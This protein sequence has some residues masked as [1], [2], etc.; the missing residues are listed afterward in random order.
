MLLKQQAYIYSLNEKEIHLKIKAK[1][2]ELILKR[3][4]HIVKAI[5]NVLGKIRIIFQKIIPRIIKTR[6]NPQKSMK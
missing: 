6:M 3:E 1:W 5:E 4:S 2:Y